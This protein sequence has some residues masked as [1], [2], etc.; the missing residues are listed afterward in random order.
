[1]G[2]GIEIGMVM[3]EL[4]GC[5]GAAMAG[6]SSANAQT[7]VAALSPAQ[8]YD[9]VSSVRVPTLH[10]RT[11]FASR[12]LQYEDAD[13]VVG[14]S[15]AGQ[16]TVQMVMVPHEDAGDG[17]DG[18]ELHQMV[19]VATHWDGDGDGLEGLTNCDWD[20]RMVGDT[21]SACVMVRMIQG[22][23]QDYGEVDENRLRE[24]PSMDLKRHE[25][26]HELAPVLVAGH[27]GA[28]V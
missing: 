15:W 13:T 14:D 3:V 25:W 23:A 12:V 26:V 9:M 24:S 17:R 19:G 20:K 27:E 18:I 28:V 21:S 5:I 22:M 6:Q 16:H 10:C 8:S 4:T 2:M 11:V 7:R 1:M